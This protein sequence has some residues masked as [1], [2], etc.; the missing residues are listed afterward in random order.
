[1]LKKID[2]FTAAIGA[3]LVAT[4]LCVLPQSTNPGSRMA[5]MAAYCRT[6]S[7]EIG[8]YVEKDWTVDWA[9]TPDGKTYSNKAPAPILIGVPF[10]C[11][12][13]R[14]MNG[15]APSIEAQERARKPVT[16]LLALLFQIL[17]F[18][19]GVRRLQRQYLAQ[20]TAESAIVFFTVAALFAN[21][22]SLFMNTW[23]GHGLVAATVLWAWIFFTEGRLAR[24]GFALALAVASDYPTALVVLA[25]LV[26]VFL[27]PRFAGHGRWRAL[28]AFA[29]GAALPSIAMLLYHHHCFGNPFYVPYRF[30]NP[31]FVDLGGRGNSFLGIFSMLPDFSALRE[32]L[33]GARRGLLW[34]QPWVFAALALVPVLWRRRESRSTVVI[35]IGGFLGLL[36]MNASFGQWHAGATPG[37]R[38]LSAAFPLLA[39]LACE[40]KV[41]WGAT[42]GALGFVL[43]LPGIALFAT[44]YSTT[45]IFPEDRALW[46]EAVNKILSLSG[47]ASIRFVILVGLFLLLAFAWKGRTK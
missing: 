40:A 29:A 33:F 3:F 14:I 42:L 35:L 22:A 43:L 9:R 45:V 47:T 18:A 37:P 13:D 31:A 21:T 6:G 34:T 27:D 20:G 2:F 12:V 8:E 44:V 17:P 23:F 38:Y 10:F 36:W 4:T 16:L 41:R 26:G 25:F 19:W 7:F 15:N 30:Q 28:L 5:A 24:S 46:G 32:L 11:A 1:M 39:L